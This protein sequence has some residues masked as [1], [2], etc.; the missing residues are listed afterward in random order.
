[1]VYFSLPLKDFHTRTEIYNDWPNSLA[2]APVAGVPAFIHPPCLQRSQNVR[3]AS[4]PPSL[5]GGILWNPWR[6]SF[7]THIYFIPKVKYTPYISIFESP[8]YHY[9]YTL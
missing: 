1:M 5:M 2:S 8:Y 7:S 3:T 6:R 9:Y 4:D